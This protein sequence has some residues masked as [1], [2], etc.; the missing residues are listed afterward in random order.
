[1]L[2]KLPLLRSLLSGSYRAWI[3]KNEPDASALQAQRLEAWAPGEQPLI[4]IVV[5]IFSPGL[6][7]LQ[8][9]LQSVRAQT[10]QHWELCLAIAGPPSRGLLQVLQDYAAQDARIHFSLLETN[11]GIAGN[12][13]AAIE[14][15]QGVFIAFLDHDDC[16]A[17]FALYAV[18]KA[19]NQFPQ[20]DLFYSDEDYL[21]PEGR[22]RSDPVFR[23]AF[24]ID[25]LRANNYLPHFLVLRKHLG[26][27]LGWLRAGF[28]GAQDYDLLLRAVEQSRFITHLPQI[29]YHCRALPA[30]TAS[31]QADKTSTN[32][33][34]LRAIQ[35]HLLRCGLPAQVSL[36]QQAGLYRVTY[37]LRQR[38]LISIIIPNHE[39]AA[40]LLR[41][42]DAIITK[43]SYPHFEI[44]IVEN[45]SHSP[46][47]FSLYSQ[48]QARDGR[49][50]I[51]EFPSGEFNYSGINNYAARQASG[52]F[53]LFLNN[54]TQVI[55][56]DWLE[57][58]L[59][60]AQRPDVGAVGAKLYYP[61]L[62]IQHAGVLLG[63]GA[64]A[65]HH[66]VGAAADDPGYR[67]N[68]V[69][70]QNL[71]AVT[72]ACLMLR[73]TVFEEV[74]GFD[75]EYPVVF[76]DVDLCL[77]I[78]QKGYQIVWTPY[79]ELIHYESLTRGYDDS[80]LKEARFQQQASLLTTRW[81]DLLAAGDPF[82]NPNLTLVMG[83]IS[84]KS[85]KCDQTV[86]CSPGL[87][88]NENQFRSTAN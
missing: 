24:S 49:V 86:R 81:A 44:L 80:L 28:E 13:N 45:N 56:P 3:R 38:P 63:I 58:M 87:A 84:V 85:E 33:A 69:L 25:Y 50:H 48:L 83:T 7:V 60:Y 35:E 79:A 54:D 31:S 4:S 72:A 52:E 30:S 74:A 34:G 64:G 26:D 9:M 75:L 66:S 68:L 47:I 46:Q 16:L 76:G 53:L 71:S 12:T 11:R 19:L 43:S 21:S 42:I 29:L 62:L 65:S 10:Y 37:P 41:C 57:R 40:D 27:R 23:P 82:F 55:N 70:P 61:N 18:A 15:A 8:A 22:Q 88:K 6:F 59:E 51:L 2:R 77:K 20:T 14:L 39:H 32:Q 36:G 67:F 17:P 73:R 78:R 5:P 1:M